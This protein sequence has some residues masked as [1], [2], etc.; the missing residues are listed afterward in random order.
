MYY[1]RVT[2]TIRTH[3]IRPV[4]VYRTLAVHRGGDDVDV[5]TTSGQLRQQGGSDDG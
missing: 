1:H 4:T 2:Y 3:A 5:A